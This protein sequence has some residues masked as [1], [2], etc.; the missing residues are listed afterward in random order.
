VERRR[1]FAIATLLG[2]TKAQLRGFVLSE[3]AVTTVAG[4]TVGA[5]AGWATSGMLIAVLGGVFD[6]PPET[7]AVPGPYLALLLAV[8]VTG[9]L[10]ADLIALRGRRVSAIDALRE[11]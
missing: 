1:T 2:A 10:A 4:I 5:A 11:P 8:T 3:G 7:P 6:P 9:I